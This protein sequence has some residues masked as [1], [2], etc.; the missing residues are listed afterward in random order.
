[1]ARTRTTIEDVALLAQ[2]SKVTVSYVLNGRGAQ[3]RISPATSEKVREAARELGYRPNGLARRL[4]SSRTHTIALAFQYAGLF[5]SESGFINELMAGV[6][7]TATQYGYDLVLHTRAPQPD[8]NDADVLTDGRCDGA[9]LLRDRD[10]PIAAD[11][12]NRNFPSVLFFT[13]AAD[14]RVSFVD[15]DNFGGADMAVKY[16]ADQGHR[17]IGLVHGSDAAYASFERRRGFEHAIAELGL[18][19]R[20]DWRFQMGWAHDDP[21]L[22]IE[23]LQKEDRPT[24]LVCWSD[25]VALEVLRIARNLC[26]CIPGDLAVIGFDSLPQC[27]RAEPPL[28]SVR[29]PVR[30]MAARATVALI[31]AIEG[32][33]ETPVRDL[34]PLTIDLRRSA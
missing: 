1:M 30:V 34:I 2:V 21:S 10:D 4:L 16:L 15:A 22:L 9:L 32:R 12:A 5:A 25:D 27:E 7:E 18:E 11:L 23:A 20:Q 8:E 31:D 6:C 17:K 33:R 28:T 14:P 3:A 24:A 13:H 19:D 26:L 29:Q